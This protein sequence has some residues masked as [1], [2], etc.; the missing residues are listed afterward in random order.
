MEQKRKDVISLRR[1]LDRASEFTKNLR[2]GTVDV[3]DYNVQPYSKKS[4]S[5]RARQDD[6]HM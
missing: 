3:D 2:E 4:S 5:H 6:I 1:Q